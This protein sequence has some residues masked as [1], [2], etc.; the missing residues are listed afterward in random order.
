MTS[1][2]HGEGSTADA[3]VLDLLLADPRQLFNTMDPAPF[4]DRDLDPNAE[5]YIV[6]WARESRADQP[7][8]LRIVLDRD[9]GTGAVLG[10]AIRKHFAHCEDMQRRRLRQLFR[11]GRISLVIGLACLAGAIV[12]ADLVGA[13]IPRERTAAL[14]QETFVIGGWV[15]LW[16]PMEIYLYDWWPIRAE[17]RLYERLRQATVKIDAALRS[18]S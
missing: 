13:M 12:V 16:R 5:A 6:G 11:T 3:A 10:E 7:L 1:A 14:V 2:R 15:A 17:M 4:R 8:A 18:A 9:D